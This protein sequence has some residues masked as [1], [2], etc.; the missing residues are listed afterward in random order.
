[1]SKVG[2]SS[3]KYVLTLALTATLLSACE[4]PLR[5]S[6]L[7]RLPVP[8]TSGGTRTE[9]GVE[10]DE[11][12][13]RPEEGLPSR[14]YGV[15]AFQKEVL[16]D[17]GATIE[18]LVVN[19]DAAPLPEVVQV[20]LGDLLKQNYVIDED[21]RGTVTLQTHGSFS[22]PAL[23]ELLESVL[24][25]NGAALVRD[26]NG[27]FRVGQSEKIRSGLAPLSRELRARLG[28]GYQTMIIHLEFATAD[29]VAKV[30]SSVTSSDVMVTPD[31]RRNL[32]MLMGGGPALAKFRELVEVFDSNW[33]EGQVVGM[34][35]LQHSSARDVKQ[36]LD[37]IMGSAE[38]KGAG[39][40]RLVTI[41]RLNAI[42]A[43]SRA[44][45][46]MREVEKWVGRLD[47][48]T[49]ASASRVYVYR[50]QNGKATDLAGVLGQIFMTGAA[51]SDPLAD[52][53]A[54]TMQAVQLE[55]GAET[56]TPGFADSP[57]GTGADEIRIIP[58]TVNNALVVMATPQE[59]RQIADALRQLD[60]APMQVIIEA[61]IIEVSL[62]DDL[63]YGIEW[64]FK[65][66]MAGSSEKEG[67]GL[68]DLAGAG[69]GPASPG[70]SYAVVDA[71]DRVRGVVNLLASRSEVEVL[72]SPSLMVLGNQTAT[73]NVG[74]E[75]PVPSRQSVSNI[76]PDA[77]T[78]NEISYRD[79]GVILGVTPRVN[80]GGLV[81]M[82]IE[83]EVS[84][85]G[86]TTTS[87]LDAPTFQQRKITSTVAVQ[88]GSTIVLGG[89]IRGR[90]SD[91][92]AGV[93]ILYQ[94]PVVGKL[95]GGTSQDTQ[96]TELLV[97]ITPRVVSD[98]SSAADVAA[99]LYKKLNYLD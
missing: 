12:A 5:R 41:D 64:F 25:M 69:I 31:A 16:D 15:E 52:S 57:F 48:G 76:D 14:I 99:E 24:E 71:A 67:R 80:A 91:A 85:V 53:V 30:L 66:D 2:P 63:E 56:M 39:A 68:L 44:P 3:H 77:P 6:P 20:I 47:L 84:N 9:V 96:R 35:P 73:I 92:E 86:P 46:L 78:V 45:S 11:S 50:V 42:L 13:Q 51:S 90:D 38:E 27:L 60:V 62:N 87:G 34:F 33:M 10:A 89:L 40:L 81:T 29:E 72:S 19:F 8:A 23:M 88:S 7:G 22:S 18:Q 61:S 21:L 94:M 4:S 17:E 26:P 95:F 83:Q 1:M 82:E 49:A 74:E 54:P 43:V 79:T 55:G 32:L 28:G 97:L 65:N 59:Y 70:F 75:V 36:E 98:A 93:P 58:D 37:V